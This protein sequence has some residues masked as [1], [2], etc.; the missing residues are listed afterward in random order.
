MSKFEVSAEDVIA[1]CVDNGL[2][3]P[4]EVTVGQYEIVIESVGREDMAMDA[5]SLFTSGVGILW[6]YDNN[7]STQEL[8]VE[9]Q[10]ESRG[11]IETKATIQRVV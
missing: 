7:P 8:K 2:P 4:D 10:S 3:T 9:V 5:V 11:N 6:D 1:L